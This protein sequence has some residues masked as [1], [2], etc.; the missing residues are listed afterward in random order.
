MK[1]I[2]GKVAIITGST[3][4]IGSATAMLFAEEG[5]KVVV[6]GRNAERGN[7]V[8]DV[9]KAK[10]G[11]AILF[12]GD[13]TDE[14]EL[15]KLI[16]TTIQKFGKLDILMNNVAMFNLTAPAIETITGEEWDSYFA[17]NVKPVFLL[18][19]LAYPYLK[20]TKGNIV[21]IASIAALMASDQYAYCSTKA[22][23]VR[24][25][26]CLASEFAKSGV[27]VNVIC[28][29]IIDTPLLKLEDA[30]VL[31]GMV[32]LGSV[33]QPEDIAK[34]ALFTASDDSSWMTGSVLV[35]D[36]GHTM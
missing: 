29:G 1:K 35:I 15:E 7:K 16:A 8:V 18:S 23:I 27:R 20:N 31:N 24:L 30:S 17:T 25:T 26:K 19:K 13:V 11:E 9:I 34:A 28:P 3:S 21:N 12:I 33:G 5:A 14:N 22:A 32:P 6:V 2:E 4:G 10:G 36:G